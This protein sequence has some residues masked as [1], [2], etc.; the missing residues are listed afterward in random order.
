[1]TAAW[2]A[3]QGPAPYLLTESGTTYVLDTDIATSSTAFVVGAANVTLDLN[4][5]TVTY[6]S[7]AS[8][9]VTNG[10]FEAPYNSDGSVPGWNLSGAP[11][12]IL[13]PNTDY[14]FGNQVL[15]LNNFSTP[16]TIVSDPIS[17]P[18]ANHDYTASIIPGGQGDPAGTTTLTFQVI[19]LTT[20][21]VLAT[22]DDNSIVNRGIVDPVT[23]FATTTDPVELQ[24]VVDPNSSSAAAEAYAAANGM[25]V[26]ATTVNLDDAAIMR[27]FDYG[28]VATQLWGTTTNPPGNGGDFGM[29]FFNLPAAAQAVYKNAANFIL[30]N[31][32]PRDAGGNIVGGVF[33]GQ[34]NSYG[35]SCFWCGEIGGG[36]TM[37]NVACGV[38]GLDAECVNGLEAQGPVA[39]QNCTFNLG[40]Y[41]IA[42]R[43]LDTAAIDLSE[44][45][46]NVTVENNQIS[47]SGQ[48]GIGLSDIQGYQIVVQDNNISMLSLVTNGYGILTNAI[49]NFTIAGNT[50]ISQQ[51]TPSL[52]QTSGSRGILIDG[53]EGLTEDGNIYGNYVDVWESDNR[54]Y[55]SGQAARALNLRN[56]V[57]TGIHTNIWVHDNTLIATT[58]PGL[59][60][61]AFGMRISYD[62]NGPAMNNA[63]IV[64]QDN[65]IEAITEDPTR[66]ADAFSLDGADAGVNTQVIGNTFESNNTSLQICT[67]SG[68]DVH[69]TQFISNTFVKSSQ[70]AVVPYTSV[71]CGYWVYLCDGVQLIDSRYEDGA[72]PTINWSG[73][74]AKDLSIGWLLNPV[75]QGPGGTPLAGATVQVLNAGVQVYSGTTDADGLI[76]TQLYSTADPNAPSGL[77]QVQVGGIPLVATIYTQTG[78][79]AQ[80]NPIIATSELGPF[81]VIVSSPG[82]VTSSQTL[83][84]DQSQS[85]TL[86]LVATPTV[87]VTDAGG[88]YT[89]Q[90]FAATGAVTGVG[91]ADL[92]TPT[93][94]YYA[95]TYTTATGLSGLTALP[96]APVDAGNYTVLASYTGSVDYAAQSAIATFTI[97]QKGV[98]VTTQNAGKI[99]G[100]SDPSP[101]TIADLS[102]FYA[103]D[104]ITATFSRAAGEDLGTYAITTTLVDPNGKL[105][106]YNVTD[107]GAIFTISAATPTVT[108]TDAGGAYTSQAFTATGA[109]TGANG[110]NVG[111]PVFTY[112]SG[113]YATTADMSGMAALPGAPVDVGDYTVLASYAATTDYA[114]QARLPRSR[115]ARR[116]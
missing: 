94:T 77:V 56:S 4:G 96:A 19:D 98:T 39:I 114:A 42:D 38:Q 53:Y 62:N 109:V 35:S 9:V 49:E 54:E 80:N 104:G 100:E 40:L 66:S 71:G 73:S 76:N 52:Q 78:T 107:A 95:G 15:R 48:D 37:S 24:V 61:E 81:Q 43:L 45:A 13:A 82:Y 31:S 11:S 1:M 41:T 113:T 116:P 101:L 69:G 112:Y 103:S 91:G 44:V 3:A 75:V 51:N 102:G 86:K 8:P 36:F 46:G 20:G 25:T 60:S 17:I 65:V 29:G 72:T 83:T 2:F 55:L 74:G 58:G 79:D 57:G 87:T 7:G 85:L 88:T 26:Y 90:A 68:E 84:I 50:I 34:A 12:A 32:A 105:G 111:T 99:Y 89:S 67:P 6:G 30:Q 92:G 21:L 63:G 97:S 23:F 22:S 10:G 28:V 14:L 5:H 33:S 70:G 16:Q 115:S 108:V 110:A 93:F 106:D 27:S 59:A 64:I 47:G 18:E